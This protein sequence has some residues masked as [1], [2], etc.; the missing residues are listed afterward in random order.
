MAGEAGGGEAEGY[1]HSGIASPATNVVINEKWGGLE[2]PPRRRRIVS[3]MSTLALCDLLST[4]PTA[5]N[6][7]RIARSIDAARTRP[8]EKSCTGTCSHT[9]NKS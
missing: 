8:L 4:R 7:Q 5:G 3:A 9:G 2:E 6:A 1:P